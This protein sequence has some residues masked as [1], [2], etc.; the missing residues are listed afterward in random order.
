MSP[1]LSASSCS[2][3]N[4]SFSAFCVLTIMAVCLLFSLKLQDLL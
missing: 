4:V 3:I 2:V 1:A